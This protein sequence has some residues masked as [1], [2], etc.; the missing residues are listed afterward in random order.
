M[1]KALLSVFAALAACTQLS[2]QNLWADADKEVSFSYAPN[3]Q[4]AADPYYEEADGGYI[5]ELTTATSQTWQ[6]QAFF[7]AAIATSTDKE[8]DF[9]CTLESN[10]DLNATVKF[11][12]KGN[13]GVFY[14]SDL[15]SPRPAKPRKSRR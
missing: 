6:A 3:W 12:Q 2:A 9:S 8:Y 1:R 10:Q 14:F 7:E 4:T 13:D 11:Y 5:W 15:I